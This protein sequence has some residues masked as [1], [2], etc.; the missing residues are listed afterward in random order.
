MSHAPA[1]VFGG[2]TPHAGLWLEDFSLVATSGGALLA[3]GG[4]WHPEG[5]G[6]TCRP[7]DGAAFWEASTRAWHL[8]PPLPRPRQG[9]ASVGLPDGRVLLV[10]GRDGTELELRTT[11]FWEPETRRFHEGPPLLSARAQPFA[12]SLADGTVLV[13]G[14]DFDDDLNRGTR[15]EVLWP[16]ASAWESAGQTVRLFHP[17]PVCVSGERVVIAGGRD[18]GFGFA[19]IDGQHLAPPLNQMTEIWE[20]GGR[21]WRM[22][23]PLTCAREEARGV[24]LSDGRILVVGGWGEGSALATA[25]VWEPRT[26]EWSATGS[27]PVPR[28]GFALTALPGGGAAVSGGSLN[29]AD[30]TETVELWDPVRGTWAP[31]P[32]LTGPRAGHHLVEVVPGTFL[33]VGA[34]RDAQGEL[35]TTWEVWRSGA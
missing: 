22:T 26:G 6:F 28:S 10:G 25:E 15:A 23:S 32:S 24:T 2:R 18:N 21:S 19:I 31:G 5:D 33:V 12:V 35:S 30:P 27:L 1:P 7:T 16:G 34:V 9:H 14:S 4:A 17:G 20:R 3:G 11:L 13:L 29:Y 8:L